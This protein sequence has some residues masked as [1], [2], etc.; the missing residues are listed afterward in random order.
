MGYQ[1]FVA[2][3]SLL[4]LTACAAQIKERPEPR[5]K[6]DLVGWGIRKV[7]MVELEDQTQR[8]IAPEATALVRT[9]LTQELGKRLE[10]AAALPRPGRY[11]A[12]DWC[13]AQSQ[14]QG[15]QGFVAGKVTG[16]Q[17][18]ADR[19]RVWVSLNLRLVSTEGKILWSK[20]TIGTVPIDPAKPMDQLFEEAAKTAAREFANDFIPPSDDPPHPADR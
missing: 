9:G 11:L 15:I 12:P 1:K 7:A 2:C 14:A 19:R 18:Q 17:K 3:F 4:L 10:I 6:A 8:G 13:R 16:Y 5:A 20:S